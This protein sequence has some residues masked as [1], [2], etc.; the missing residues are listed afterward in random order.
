MSAFIGM[1]DDAADLVTLPAPEMKVS[2]G[3]LPDRPTIV[4][5]PGI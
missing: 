1:M 2:L 3:S 4:V 5:M